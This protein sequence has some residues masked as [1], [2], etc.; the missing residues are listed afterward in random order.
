MNIQKHLFLLFSILVFAAGG[1]VY[2]KESIK[3]ME[4]FEEETDEE[5]EDVSGNDVP[6]LSS[7]TCPDMFHF[8]NEL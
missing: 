6:N 2:A 4:G 3:Q 7:S 5:D 8:V 1:Y